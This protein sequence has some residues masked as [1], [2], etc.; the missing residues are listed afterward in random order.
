M[1]REAAAKEEQNKPTIKFIEE[2]EVPKPKS[3]L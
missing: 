3:F 2:K 1:V